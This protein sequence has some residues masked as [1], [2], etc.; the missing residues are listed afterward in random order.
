MKPSRQPLFI[1]SN[2]PTFNPLGKPSNQPTVQPSNQPFS[3]PS[4]QPLSLP[5]SSPKRKP[6]CVPT[7]QPAVMHPSC[8]PSFQP[9]NTPSMQPFKKPMGHP[10]FQPSSQPV[11]HPTARPRGKP[12]RQPTLNPVNIPSRQ[13]IRLP[14]TQPSG[15]PSQYPTLKPS[16]RPSALPSTLPTRKPSSQ[17]VRSPTAQPA[18]RPSRAPSMQPTK[19]PRSYPS[20]QPLKV[21]TRQP[22]AQPTRQ[23]STR[24]SCQILFKPSVQPNSNPSEQPNRNPTAQ[25]S[26]QPLRNPSARP[27]NTPT[28]QPSS[29]PK[30][31]PTR[32]PFRFPTNQ[33]SKFP[34][35]VPSRGPQ[36]CPSSQPSKLPRNIPS[37]Q[38]SRYPS[39]QPYIEPTKQP[40][41]QP[42]RIPSRQPVIKPSRRPSAQPKRKPTAQPKK[43][44]SSQPSH[45]P[46]L[47]PIK[48]PSKQPS[49][50]PTG[51][52][53][54]PSSQPSKAPRVLPTRQPFNQPTRQ[55]THQPTSQPRHR[56]SL[57][58]YSL[59]S[60][61]PT[62][63]PM[64]QPTRRP[65]QQPYFRPSTQPKCKP[66]MHPSLQPYNRPTSW[67]SLSPYAH[68][69]G[70]PS[71]HPTSKP[72]SSSPTVRPSSRPT[73][74]P[75]SSAP[76]KRG[77]TGVPRFSP[78]SRPSFNA[79]FAN[80]PQ[81][82]DYSLKKQ[83]T[84]KN[85]STT[86]SFSSFAY[87]G[88]VVD[89]TCDSWNSF[90]DNNLNS[91]FDTVRFVSMNAYYAVTL[92][93]SKQSLNKSMSCDDEGVVQS[94]ISNILSGTPYSAECN[95]NVWQVFQCSGE[96]VICVNCKKS[97][98]SSTLCGGSSF[99]INPC[100]MASCSG[101]YS[102]SYFIGFGYDV[103]VYYPQ[104]KALPA[105]TP[106]QDSVSV[107][108]SLNKAG[109]VYC[110]AFAA[111]AL[112]ASV[113]DIYYSGTSLR[114]LNPA[115][116][117]TLNI[118]G[119]QP[120]TSYSVYCFTSDLSNHFMELKEAQLTHNAIQT[121]CCKK[122][123][124]QYNGTVILG[125]SSSLSTVV[126]PQYRIGLNAKP[127]SRV[128][129][130]VRLLKVACPGSPLFSDATV[131]PSTAFFTPD[132]YSLVAS[133][134]ISGTT[135][136]CFIL[137]AYTI[138]VDA[139]LSLN[140]SL[141]IY[142]SSTQPKPPI[143]T[144]AVFSSDL[145]NLIISFDS[146]TSKSLT[147]GN[148]SVVQAFPCNQIFKFNGDSSSSCS[149]SS[150]T[151]VTAFL[152]T[153]TTSP[154][155][156]DPVTLL[157]GKLQ[158][159]CTSRRK[160]SA[161][162]YSPSQSVTIST[163]AN[164]LLPSPRLSGP[165]FIGS[166]DDVQLDA[167]ASAGSGGKRWQFVG[168]NVTT[169]TSSSSIP[170]SQLLLASNL[171]SSWLNKNGKSI[172]RLIVVPANVI[173][174][175][176][177]YSLYLTVTNFLGQS[178]AVST[179]ITV[180]SKSVPQVSIIGDIQSLRRWSSTTFFASVQFSKCAA[181]AYWNS[182]I[183]YD[184]S[185]YK[186]L[187]YVGVQSTSVD[188]RYFVVAP[189]KLDTLASYTL[190]SSVF[191][192][193]VS[194]L[195]VSTSTDSQSFVLPLS[196]VRAM[197][198]GGS[199]QVLS[200][201]QEVRLSAASS[202]SLDNQFVSNLNFQWSCIVYAPNYG[203][204]CA[205]QS[206][207]S[208]NSATLTISPA[209]LV[210]NMVYNFSVSVSDNQGN[211]DLAYV[212]LQTQNTSN[213]PSVSIDLPA[214]KYDPGQAIVLTGRLNF[215]QGGQAVWTSPSIANFEASG[216][217]VT[218]LSQPFPESVASV[219][220][221]SLAANSL[222]PGLQYTIQLRAFYSTPVVFSSATVQVIMNRPP[223]GGNLG[224]EPS[225]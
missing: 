124:V 44:P 135:P 104:F 165:A 24:P 210:P 61:T 34:R 160:C 151:A 173:S 117:S 4:V 42:R 93:D 1:P 220:K 31:R 108:V 101:R 40:T 82:K 122:V 221:L 116:N 142:N 35:S 62:K 222:V 186:G 199:Y 215:A 204:S 97:C 85:I 211:I 190:R 201:N 63:Q 22:S 148:S 37:C 149:W 182:T 59:P 179:A 200:A 133:F 80:S 223:R 10:S 143:L 198:D 18:Y 217:A 68:P 127:S 120:S 131:A 216:I 95:G 57:V 189:Y 56:P 52:T 12:S 115:R 13:P 98:S 184:W 194:G 43:K 19:K 140:Q 38:P 96:S 33:P 163:P 203:G 171:L 60:R 3:H 15:I 191:Q 196:G 89:G 176:V 81:F 107:E 111:P 36:I 64:R 219:F 225:Q 202:Y 99:A 27:V 25:P 161:Y 28:K 7:I 11:A 83:E 23:P 126:I 192:Y 137:S 132:S 5:S 138:G 26:K 21:P 45:L 214:I 2:Q 16:C 49:S 46:S 109:I 119:L 170:T 178:A 6:S 50:I 168:W 105:I 164:A 48:R 17:P 206:I 74:K 123:V 71:Y 154:N 193:S 224:V 9:K 87:G 70:Q 207:V 20:S 106:R 159:L 197:I 169:T 66:T 209:T 39:K 79:Q 185:L 58:P 53:T 32:Q 152:D 8:Q 183:V 76:T 139:Y 145:Q 91:P 78:T 128:Q 72:T 130:N 153:G 162:K 205:I 90:V 69:T 157:S 134:F 156:G 54:L 75:I 187:Q 166:C 112:L 110:S 218:S 146:A 94:V 158:A 195:L 172:N 102:A 180:K 114:S 167:T 129:L 47:Q 86:Y 41:T 213:I 147:N 77:Q 136:G 73:K 29:Y 88:K 175:S 188:P 155:P 65:S 181:T 113:W 141:T 51:P 144:Q 121:L 208:L 150:L 103:L 125:S 30:S 100:S 212:L 174:A 118:T 14:S 67:P 84:I 92:F 55:P 177:S